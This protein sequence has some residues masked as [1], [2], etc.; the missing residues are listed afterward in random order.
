M[1]YR[2]AYGTACVSR[3]T[4]RSAGKLK[5]HDSGAEVRQRGCVVLYLLS[6]TASY[7]DST[8]DKMTDVMTVD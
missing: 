4:V 3:L 6:T 2:L 1:C 7:T 8:F 5:V